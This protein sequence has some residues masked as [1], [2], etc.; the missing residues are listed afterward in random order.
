MEWVIFIDFLLL[1]EIQRKRW[2]YRV[3]H[4]RFFFCFVEQWLLKI[5][6]STILNKYHG[7]D[8]VCYMHKAHTFHFMSFKWTQIESLAKRLAYFQ[9]N[10]QCS[11]TSHLH[12]AAANTSAYTHAANKR[13]KNVWTRQSNIRPS[14]L[15]WLW[16]LVH[17]S[18]KHIFGR[19]EP[20]VWNAHNKH[21]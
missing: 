5:T 21:E 9:G 4:S 13:H 11:P 7:G 2:N 16:K 1:L 10:H 19:H 3:L 6:L 14:F 20:N 12:T 8:F 18:T 17:N 15:E